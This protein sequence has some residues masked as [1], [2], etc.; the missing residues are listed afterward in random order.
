MKLT[1]RGK[2]VLGIVLALAFIGIQ[3]VLANVNWVGDHYCW[4]SFVKC[5]YGGK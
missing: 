5:Y 1:K 2:V 4:G 3:Y